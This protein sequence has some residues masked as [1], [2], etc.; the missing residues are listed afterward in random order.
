MPT[1]ALRALP[2][3][4]V[5]DGE[6]FEVSS[7]VTEEEIR[8]ALPFWVSIDDINRFRHA[9]NVMHVR[10]RLPDPAPRDDGSGTVRLRDRIYL[11]A[12]TSARL[13]LMGS[14]I[15]YRDNASLEEPLHITSPDAG[16]Y[17][18]TINVAVRRGYPPSELAR[19]RREHQAAQ[20][21]EDRRERARRDRPTRP[22]PPK[23]PRRT[24][25]DV[26]AA[27]DEPWVAGTK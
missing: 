5:L 8:E 25:W 1:P 21:E 6:T 23:P 26:I 2:G 13:D 14:P 11:G 15:V 12:N 7:T 16:L 20:A 9:P 19:L 17:A 22:P 18:S 10:L 3:Y 24:A 27:D 4:R